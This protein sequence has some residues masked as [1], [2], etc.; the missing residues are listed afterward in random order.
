MR[1]FPAL[2]LPLLLSTV[3][4]ATPVEVDA[5]GVTARTPNLAGGWVGDP[6]VLHLHVVHRFWSVGDGSDDKLL[7]SPTLVAALPLPGRTLV[8]TRYASNSLVAGGRVNE[9]ELFGRWSPALSPTWGGSLTVAHN[10]AA[11]GLDGEVEGW[12]NLSDL[13]LMGSFRRLGDALGS[14]ESGT[15]AGAGV[16]YR[17]GPNLGL[18]ADIGWALGEDG[19]LA[20]NDAVWG[21]GIQ[22]GIP[23][24]PHT[25]SLH[26]ANTRTG[27]LQGSS[28]PFRT[29]WGFEFTVPL[30]PARYLPRRA[31][32]SATPPPAPLRGDDDDP[33]FQVTMDDRMRFLPDTIRIPVGSVVRWENTS[34]VIHTVTADPSVGMG[35]EYM[36]LP[37]GAEPF[38]SG[39]LFPGEAFEHRFT[40]P[41]T[42]F[43]LCLPHVSAAM[44]GVVEVVP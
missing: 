29:L 18:A 9:W 4:A 3:V 1:V 2:S 36:R 26:V 30:T 23:T 28:T 31:A 34:T 38:D 16:L 33:V 6:G 5:Q 20:D 44:W 39:I 19:P 8:G 40:V 42:Y 22:L 37:E 10:R 27:T 21:A 7:N 14:G 41:G 11:G 24:T 32:G 15:I 13:T 35:T 43:Y 25:L 17:V 12:V